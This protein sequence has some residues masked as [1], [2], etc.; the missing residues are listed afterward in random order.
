MSEVI[1]KAAI[2]E[3]KDCPCCEYPLTKIND[4]LFCTNDSCP[5]RVGKSI[6]HFCK[7][8]GIKGLGPKTIEKLKISSITE[9]FFLDEEEVKSVLGEK[10]A[11][12]LLSEIETSKNA[13][14]E[15]VLSSLSIPLIGATAAKKLCGVIEDI[16]E[17]SA[18]TCKKAGLGE[19]AS[20]NLLLWLE[21]EGKDLIPFLPFSFKTG[22]LNI[23]NKSVCIT[24]KLKTFKTK[25]DAKILLSV[26]GYTVTESV[27]KNTYA[28][29]DESNSNSAKRNL[30]EKYGILIIDDINKLLKEI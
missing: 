4:Q 6:E 11:A 24:G 1:Q 30:A 28:L 26:A 25:A 10:V 9:I 17:I 13:D 18:I 20:N 21:T 8:M 27:T 3:P 12:K 23:N 14:L 5:A 29:I 15:T 16:S 7:V 2:I 22:K 19:K